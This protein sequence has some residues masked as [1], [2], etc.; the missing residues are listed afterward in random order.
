ML[1]QPSQSLSHVGHLR[2]LFLAALFPAAAALFPAAATLAAQTCRLVAD[3]NPGP[4]PSA[5]SGMCCSRGNILFFS[6]SDGHTGQEPWISHGGGKPV[7]LRDIRSRGGSCPRD[8][9]ACGSLVFF[10][11]DDG[12]TG[13]ELWASDS[14]TAGTRLVKDIRATG[15]RGSDIRDIVCI[16]KRVVF[17]A[18]DGTHGGEIWTSDGTRAGT[19]LLRDIRPGAIGSLPTSIAASGGRAFFGANDGAHG[20]E[21]WVSDGTTAG[22][23]LVKDLNPGSSR[24]T[25]T[26]MFCHLG[27]VFFSANAGRTG[28]ELFQSDGTK[29][30]TVLVKDINTRGSSFPHFFTTCG[31]KLFFVAS[32]QLLGA[33]LYVHDAS[34][35][36]LVR[37]L[38]KPGSSSPSHLVCAGGTLFFSASTAASGTEL[39]RSDGTASGT[40]LVKDLRA[41]TASSSPSELRSVGSRVYLQANDG[42]RTGLWVS[43]GT[44]AGTK[45]ICVPLQDPRNLVLCGCRLLFSAFTPQLSHELYALDLP[46]A[47][48]TAFA[49]SCAPQNA[50]LSATLPLLGTTMT[51][52]GAHG[53]ARS[54]RLLLLDLVPR[55]ALNLPN[56]CSVVVNPLVVLG[57]GTS[58]TWTLR[59]PIPNSPAFDGIC[60]ATQVVWI[61]LPTLFPVH[62]TN[63]LLLGFGR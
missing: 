16:G 63:A 43:D 34:G 59:L 46:G 40:V 1:H 2:C 49:A 41:G 22:T 55:P 51:F 44:A 42:T 48:V 11:A 57:V 21:L 19:F 14:T 12:V 24:S 62:T 13:R 20:A 27:T 5:P 30:G 26:G 52:S 18:D 35:T 29:S 47:S 53:P 7:R 60:L 10:T 8:F 4:A 31:K 6:A 45:Q 36:R 39:W 56:G 54:A 32:T 61:K 23:V 25:P 50:T 58:P 28:V 37:D 38:R 3:I 15:R 17:R 9:V 33:E